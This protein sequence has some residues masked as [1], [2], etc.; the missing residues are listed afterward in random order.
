MS[1]TTYETAKIDN[2]TMRLSAAMN[3]VSALGS[4]F[5]NSGEI[6][7]PSN[8]VISG[9]LF[10]AEVLMEDAHTALAADTTSG[11]TA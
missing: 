9:A 6:Q 10:A 1:T 5:G 4:Y 2:A 11:V 3:V 8:E 7:R